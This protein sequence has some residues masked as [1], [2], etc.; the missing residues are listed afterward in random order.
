MKLTGSAEQGIPC[1]EPCDAGFHGRSRFVSEE[2]LV[3]NRIPLCELCFFDR[4]SGGRDLEKLA[5][6]IKEGVSLTGGF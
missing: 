4:E 2:P 5:K 1:L 3:H 6:L